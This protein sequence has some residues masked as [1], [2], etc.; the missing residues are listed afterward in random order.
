VCNDFGNNG[1]YSA[2]LRAFSQIR[3]P[4]VF[5]KAAPNLEPRDDIWP[6]EMAPVFRRRDD[7]VELVQLRWG[8]PPARPK[9]APIINFRSEGR[10]FPKGRCLIPASH[11]FEFT[12]AKAPKSK[13]K[14]TTAGED[15]FCFAGLWRPMPPV[16]E[17]RSRY[18]RLSQAL[19]SRRSTIGIWLSSTARIGW[20][21]SI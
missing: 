4:I 11:F 12:G 5:P 18:L 16:Q 21:G 9:G 7:G 20:P 3:A 19:T 2:Y 13:W 15:W 14:F 6:T 8:F 1:P 17:T 10:R